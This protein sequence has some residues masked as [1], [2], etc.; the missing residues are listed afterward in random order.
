MDYELLGLI[1][2]AVL[3]LYPALFGIYQRIGRYDTL[4]EEFRVHLREQNRQTETIH[5]PGDYQHH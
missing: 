4:C 2:G 1:L 5:G 3:P